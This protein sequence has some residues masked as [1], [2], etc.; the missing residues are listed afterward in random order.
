MRLTKENYYSTEADLAY[1]S[2]SQFKAFSKCEAAAAATLRGEYQRPQTTAM[3]VGSYVDAWFEG[4]L[5][6]F[7]QAH[8]EIFTKAGLLKADYMRAEEVIARCMRDP[9]FMS[10]MGGRKQV[11]KTATLFGAR[12]KIK[13]DSYFPP[14]KQATGRVVDLK[15]VRSLD[16]INGISLV[17]YWDYD[18]QMAVY[19]AVESHNPDTCLAI[20]TKEDEPNLELVE[21]PRWRREECLARVEREL[22]R[23]LAIKRGKEEPRRCGVCDYCR[24]T[25]VLEKPIDFEDL[26][27]SRQELD[28]MKGVYL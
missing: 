13:M 4:T 3:L 24:R 11:I 10:Y 21:I 1:M 17:E 15:I 28:A 9:L 8:P 27:F 12:W 18:L 16:R 26:G 6:N 25:K 2:V 22:P 19:A 14:T 7:R 23:Y 5:D 20:A